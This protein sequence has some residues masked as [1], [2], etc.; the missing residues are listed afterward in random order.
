MIKRSY[1]ATE[2][3]I[4]FQ[5]DKAPAHSSQTNYINSTF[6]KVYKKSK[7]HKTD[8]SLIIIPNISALLIKNAS[9]TLKDF[10]AI[11]TN[12]FGNAL[13]SALGILKINIEFFRV[14]YIINKSN[15]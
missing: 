2:M 6:S 14:S 3:N 11:F 10:H 4:F 13:T 5:C 7:Q 8:W 9:K 12:E 1:L 15:Q